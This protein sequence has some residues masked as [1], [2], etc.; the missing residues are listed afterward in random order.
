M[1]KIWAIA[2]TVFR[3]LFR[4][5][6]GW[7]ILAAIAATAAFIF[8]TSQADG[9]LLHELQLRIRYSASFASILISLCLLFLA[10]ISIRHD[11]DNKQMH[12]LSSWPIHRSEIWLGKWL[13]LLLFSALAFAVSIATISLCSWGYLRNWKH[14]AEKQ[15]LASKFWRTMH[16]TPP[17]RKPLREQAEILYRQ[18]LLKGELPQDQPAWSIKNEIY[19]ELRRDVQMLPPGQTKTWRFELGDKPIVGQSVVLRY[20]IFAEQERQKIFGTWTVEAVDGVDRFEKAFEVY[21]YRTGEIEV[22]AALVPPSGSLRVTFKGAPNT[23]HLI[24]PHDQGMAILFDDGSL[25]ANVTRGLL[26]SL[27]HQA[28]LIAVGLGAASAFTMAVATFVSLILFGLAISSQF[29]LGVIGDLL[30]Q[31][32]TFVKMLGAKVIRV[33]IWLGQGLRPPPVIA[34]V[35]G[36]RSIRFAEI[37]ASWGGASLLYFILIAGLGIYLLTRKELDRI[38]K[39]D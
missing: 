37:W 14:P 22:P 6:T 28:V 4:N 24:F 11:I 15:V 26:V 16:E 5:G 25:A 18:R 20:K 35:S 23:P 13:G 34:E 39:Q 19:R 27:A 36:G 29:F 2:K 30:W 9:V 3:L 21:P 8:L 12:M 38:Q 31:E 17:A 33:G 1:T 10:C 7:G 32:P